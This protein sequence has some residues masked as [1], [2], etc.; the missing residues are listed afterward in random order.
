MKIYPKLD[1]ETSFQNCGSWWLIILSGPEEQIELTFNGLFNLGA[2]NAANALEYT[3]HTRTKA[4]FWST[5]EYMFKFFYESYLLRH[6]QASLTN[7]AQLYA[8][9][10]IEKLKACSVPFFNFNRTCYVDTFD[11]GTCT[12]ERPDDNYREQATLRAH[13]N[14]SA[15]TIDKE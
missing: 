9:T 6:G 8:N 12:A 15:Q 3:D 7:Q 4:V 1:V 5:P 10:E 14:A 11:Q 2:S 13:A